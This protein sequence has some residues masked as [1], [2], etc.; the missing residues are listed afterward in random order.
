MRRDADELTRLS[1]SRSELQVG[2]ERHTRQS[3]SATLPLSTAMNMQTHRIEGGLA[4]RR[5]V[6]SPPIVS[7]AP[8]EAIGRRQLVRG[9]RSRK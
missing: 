1:I 3:V 6:E 9:G 7:F 5:R 4:A 8:D 2:C